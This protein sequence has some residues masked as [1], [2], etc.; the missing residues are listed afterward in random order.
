MPPPPATKTALRQLT[1]PI[2]G[3]TCANCVAAVE[4]NLKKVDGVQVANVNLSSERATLEFD[5]FLAGLPD[6]LARIER[7]GYGVATGEADFLVQRLDDDNDARRLEKT[8]AEIE[9]VLEAQVGL[10]TERAR[11]RYIPT[12]VSQA[13]LRKAAASAGFGIAGAAA[14]ADTGTAAEAE[15]A[16][17]KA[18]EQEI[19]RQ[20]HFLIVGLLFTAP[21][22]AFSMARDFGLL[23]HWAHEPWA[24]WLMFALATPVQFYVGWQ[25]YGG[26]FKALRNRSANMDVLIAMGSSTAYFYSVVILLGFLPGHTYFE[27]AAMIITLIKVG[28]FLEARAKGRT[29]AAIKKLMSLRA[30]TARVIRNGEEREIPADEVQVGDLVIVRPGE[31]IPVDGVVVEGRSAVD[32]A[33][34]TGESLPVEKGPGDPVT[35]ATL[36]KLGLLK[37]E[38]LKVGRETALAQIIRLVEEAQGSKAPIQK[39]TDQV[40]AVFVPAVLVIAALTFLAWYLIL[41]RFSIY[42]SAGSPFTTALI[43]TVAVLVIACPCAMGLATPTAVMVG[44]GKGAELGI[45]LKSGE[46]LERAGRLTTVVLDKTGTITKGQPAVTDIVTGEQSA[47]AGDRL[48]RLAASV[49]QGSEHPLGEAIWA[50]A[51]NR[52]L[53]LSQPE[54]FQAIVGRGVRAVVEGHEILVGNP[55]MMEERTGTRFLPGAWFPGAVARFQSEAKTAMLVAVDGQVAGIIAVADTLKEGSAEAVGELHGM[56]LRVLMITGDNR[57]TAETIARRVGIDEVLAEVLPGDKAAEIERLQNTSNARRQAGSHIAHRLFRIPS[58]QTEVVAMVGDG[59]ND[60]PA[61]AQADVGIAL[62]TGTDVAMAAAPITLISGDLRGV[63]RAIALSRR[64][65]RTIQ[66]NLF[67][68][69]IYNLILIPAAA[70]GFLN[71]ILAAGAMAFSS[72]FVVTNSLRLRR[73]RF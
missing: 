36:N 70:A 8:L 68:A 19:A 22:F 71:P 52:G 34:L 29:S 20:R 26:A 65:L 6:F 42:E 44:T 57:Q 58:A 39:L 30:R 27:T 72:I 73:H 56:G 48:L 41:P 28:K 43:N 60:A 2:T 7:A 5:P 53:S 55:R 66:Q 64:T 47:A 33:M 13:D 16:E 15:D 31:K 54:G 32:E 25:Y 51:G 37:F 18:R 46:A 35:G 17:A 69:F 38:A 63:P 50:E 49:E 3:M 24:D 67:W 12:L 4:R 21:L 11:V 10:A 59:I 62:G 14:G 23:P 61:L 9:G 1:L 40:S 45:L